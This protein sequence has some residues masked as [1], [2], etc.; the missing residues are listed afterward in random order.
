MRTLLNRVRS[1]WYK[2]LQFNQ[3]SWFR[4][5]VNTWE[6]FFIIHDDPLILSNSNK[7]VNTKY[8][9]NLNFKNMLHLNLIFFK[10]HKCLLKHHEIQVLYTKSWR[11]KSKI[12][13]ALGFLTSSVAT[14]FVVTY[15]CP[16]CLHPVM[17]QLSYALNNCSSCCLIMWMWDI[18]HCSFSF[19][20]AWASFVQNKRLGPLLKGVFGYYSHRIGCHSIMFSVLFELKLISLIWPECKRQ[21]EVLEPCLVKVVRTNH[22]KLEY[23]FV[24]IQNNMIF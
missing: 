5:I 13:M 20:I 11:P 19:H 15:F 8:T 18:S 2:F 16:M 17:D 1:F 22:F 4:V 23:I 12:I 3:I 21:L 6:K 9:Q 10:S 14:L 24:S 7:I